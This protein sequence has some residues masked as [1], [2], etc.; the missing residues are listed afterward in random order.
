MSTQ[1]RKPDINSIRRHN[2]YRQRLFELKLQ[3]RENLKGL[4]PAA[5]PI[6]NHEG[7]ELVFD[8][9]G[10]NGE[11]DCEDFRSEYHVKDDNV[12]KLVD[13]H[14]NKL[15][16]AEV[17]DTDDVVNDNDN[18]MKENETTHTQRHNKT[19]K[20]LKMLALERA[21]QQV[22]WGEKMKNNEIY[23]MDLISRSN[24]WL[25]HRNEKREKAREEK[26]IAA[27]KD[28]SMV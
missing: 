11:E 8:A 19:S 7:D 2:N 21:R 12:A 1:L 23:E 27:I 25:K 17:V 6:Q 18:D 5:D 28:V 4:V 16:A 26:E 22:L 13:I 15:D 20:N 10:V 24:L 3:K 14:D 9:C